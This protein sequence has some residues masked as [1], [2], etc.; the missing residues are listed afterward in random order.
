MLILQNLKTLQIKLK[1]YQKKKIMYKLKDRRMIFLPKDK[2][3]K[4]K[5]SNCREMKKT[6]NKMKDY[7]K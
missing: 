7:K 2:S 5:E 6:E 4:K 3:K 1:P